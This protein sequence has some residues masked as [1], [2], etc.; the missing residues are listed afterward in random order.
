MYTFI[1]CNNEQ[2][3]VFKP[4]TVRTYYAIKRSQIEVKTAAD[5]VV[6]AGMILDRKIRNAGLVTVVELLR[7]AGYGVYQIFGVLDGRWS[8]DRVKMF[9]D[10]FDYTLHETW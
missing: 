9:C 1:N 8:L 4:W 6:V 2:E 3:Q 5:C 10:R 7:G